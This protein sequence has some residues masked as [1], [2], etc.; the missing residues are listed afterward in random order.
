MTP[1]DVV[2]VPSFPGV[3]AANFADGCVSSDQSNIYQLKS[4][5]N[6]NKRIT[7]IS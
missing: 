5:I 4:K 3:S 2:L 1:T 7:E 6:R